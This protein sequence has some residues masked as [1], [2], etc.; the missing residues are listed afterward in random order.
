MFQV[1]L[2][3]V[4]NEEEK[5]GFLVLGVLSNVPKHA[6]IDYVLDHYVGRELIL[7]TSEEALNNAHTEAIGRL[8]EDYDK[9]LIDWK[10]DGNE[11]VF[12]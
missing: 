10:D 3:K 4:W 5:E 9:V 12:A 11:M 1:E 6:S 7:Y 2:N 8:K